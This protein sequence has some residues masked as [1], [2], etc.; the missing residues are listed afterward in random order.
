MKR[1]SVWCKC[2][3][4]KWY[5]NPTWKGIG[6][7]MHID[8]YCAPELVVRK[9]KFTRTNFARVIPWFKSGSREDPPCDKKRAF[10]ERVMFAY[11]MFG[12][13]VKTPPAPDGFNV[14][15]WERPRIVDCYYEVQK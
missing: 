12:Q 15:R 4:G 9:S 3:D 7:Y 13:L 6:W 10:G 14:V 1:P 11:C 5:E 8:P 2:S